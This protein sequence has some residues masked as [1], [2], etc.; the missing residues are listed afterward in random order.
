MRMRSMMDVRRPSTYSDISSSSSPPSMYDPTGAM[1]IPVP[2]RSRLMARMKACSN[3]INQP[4]TIISHNDSSPSRISSPNIPWQ[5]AS[6]RTREVKSKVH[7]AVPYSSMAIHVPKNQSSS[8]VPT[9]IDNYTAHQRMSRISPRLSTSN[10]PVRIKHNRAT[11]PRNNHSA[12]KHVSQPIPIIPNS[13]P[14]VA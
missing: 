7:S 11:P 8:K 1:N 5:S 13:D 14:S 9:H 3:P 4:S 12:T 10:V 2:T 6:H